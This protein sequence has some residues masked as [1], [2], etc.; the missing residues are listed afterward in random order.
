MMRRRGFLAALAAT[1]A[2]PAGAEAVLKS[3]RPRHRPDHAVES[4]EKTASLITSAKLSGT[5]AYCVANRANGQVLAEM[6]ADTWVPPASV[7]KAIT[8]L[9]ALE[10]LGPAYRFTTR[11]LRVGTVQDGTLDGD[12]I[13]AGGGDPTFDTDKMGDM[14]AA[15]AATGLRRITGNFIAY[16][17]ALP[18][19]FA[20]SADQPEHLGYNPAVSGLMLNY[21]RVNFVWTHANGKVVAKMNAEGE[22]FIPPV[23]MATITVADRDQPLFTYDPKPGQDQWTVAATALSRDGSRWLPVR[24][25]APYTAEV[26]ATLCAAQGITLPPAQVTTTPPPTEAAE[27]VAH[28]SD[29]L[30]DL[31]RKMLKYSTN[32]TAEAVGMTSSGAG[33]QTGSARAMSVWANR[34]FGVD[35]HMQDHSGLGSSSRVTARQMMQIMHRARAAHNGDLLQDLLRE[36]G[37]ADANGR[38]MKDSR[39][40]VHAKSGTLNFVS[41]LAGYITDKGTHT[42]TNDLCFAI[43]A[44]DPDRRAAVPMQDREDPPGGSAWTKRARR[45]Q[46]QLISLWSTDLH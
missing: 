25:P 11:V 44:A 4:T 5:L 45:L 22:R 39:V 2:W 40:R 26:F 46:S 19:R 42:G 20:I 16:S 41:G 43:F 28:Q 21:N 17:G 8:T 38:E 13:L 27:L 30:P 34:R 3:I 33:T 18:E 9:Y 23:H 1:A 35:I 12:L 7:A 29:T 36:Y 37:V 32:L 14:V 31:L 6:N 10:K 15:L 24:Q